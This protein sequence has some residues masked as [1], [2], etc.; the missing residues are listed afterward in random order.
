MTQKTNKFDTI[1]YDG[2]NFKGHTHFNWRGLVVNEG[3]FPSIAVQWWGPG[4]I[5][6]WYYLAFKW[7]GQVYHFVRGGP[8]GKAN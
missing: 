3:K 4:R 6:F 2:P 7:R 1:G 5:K 8:Y